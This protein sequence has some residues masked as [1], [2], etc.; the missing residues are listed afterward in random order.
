MICKQCGEIKLTELFRPY[1]HRSGNYPICKDCEKINTRY[2]YIINKIPKELRGLYDEAEKILSAT[3]LQEMA[4]IERWYE[5]LTSKGLKVPRFGTGR[6]RSNLDIESKINKLIEEAIEPTEHTPTE[7]I[8]WLSRKLDEYDAEY[9]L[10]VVYEDLKK[11]YRPV[12]GIDQTTFLPIYDDKYKDTLD[13][14]LKRFNDYED[15]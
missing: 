8:I 14:I 2:K 4:G 15:M 13:E 6:K 5:L 9:L 3:E 7:L 10:D 12:I 11:K 1:Y